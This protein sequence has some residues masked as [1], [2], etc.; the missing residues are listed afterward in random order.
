MATHSIVGK[1]NTPQLCSFRQGNHVLV[2]MDLISLHIF[3]RVFQG[4]VAVGS[5]RPVAHRHDIVPP[6][7]TCDSRTLLPIDPVGRTKQGI[8]TD[9]VFCSNRHNI[10]V[11]QGQR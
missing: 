10:V 1:E 9:V 5:Y 11:T 7:S 4:C 3:D 2:L 6:R 8:Y